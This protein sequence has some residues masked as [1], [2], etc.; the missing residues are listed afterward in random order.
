MNKIV[1]AM[2]PALEPIAPIPAVKDIIGKAL[3]H[4]GSYNELDNKKQVVALIDDVH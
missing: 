1:K 3:I 4:I 2:R